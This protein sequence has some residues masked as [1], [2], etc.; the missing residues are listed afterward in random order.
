MI[1]KSPCQKNSPRNSAHRR[2]KQT[3][4]TRW[5]EVSVHRRRKDKEPE[6]SIDSTPHNQT[7]EQQK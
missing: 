3:K 4:I 1:T 5:R 2:W 6:S 7:P